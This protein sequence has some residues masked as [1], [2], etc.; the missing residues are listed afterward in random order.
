MTDFQL[1]APLKQTS[2]QSPV[3]PLSPTNRPQPFPSQARD[4]L[5]ARPQTASN[6]PNKPVSPFTQSLFPTIPKPILTHVPVNPEPFI[7]QPA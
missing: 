3:T 4:N 5:Q 2:N 1:H 6:Q 7:P